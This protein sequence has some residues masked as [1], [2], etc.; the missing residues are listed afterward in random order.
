[1]YFKWAASLLKLIGLSTII[2]NN[3]PG[4][5][6]KLLMLIVEI[7]TKPSR[8]TQSRFENQIHELGSKGRTRL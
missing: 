5:F 3:Q 2:L 4:C 8:F 6:K 7:D 1:M